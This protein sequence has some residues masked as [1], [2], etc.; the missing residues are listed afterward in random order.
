MVY[1]NAKTNA[2]L[3][4]ISMRE[5]ETQG[6]NLHQSMYSGRQQKNAANA[7][8]NAAANTA[9]NTAVASQR[10]TYRR[11]V[12]DAIRDAPWAETAP[13][14]ATRRNSRNRPA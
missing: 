2:A 9:A 4:I 5:R 6:Q 3:T 8:A 7:A 10:P 12:Y 1:E 11:D 14:A 13:I